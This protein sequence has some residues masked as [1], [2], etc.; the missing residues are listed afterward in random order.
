MLTRR[1]RAGCVRRCSAA[2]ATTEIHGT[3][4]WSSDALRVTVPAGGY[5]SRS[6]STRVNVTVACLDAACASGAPNNGFLLVAFDADGAPA[7]RF[8]SGPRGALRW[9]CALRPPV[10]RL[11]TRYAPPGRASA[12]RRTPK[13]HLSCRAPCADAPRLLHAA[14]RARPAQAPR[15]PA[16]AA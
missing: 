1:A 7:G 2:A 15:P 14:R 11:R 8:V 6:A 16:P 4:S 5:D 9:R 3:R 10:A 13:P 12:P